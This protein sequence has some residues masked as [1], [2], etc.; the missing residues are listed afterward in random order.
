MM[1]WLEE[2]GSGHDLTAVRDCLLA[3]LQ[4][5]QVKGDFPEPAAATPVT[6]QTNHQPLRSF[7]QPKGRSYLDRELRRFHQASQEEQLEKL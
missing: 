2:N 5:R 6:T 7:R 1:G 3:K 4:Q